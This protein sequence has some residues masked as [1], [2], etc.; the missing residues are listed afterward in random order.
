MTCDDQRPCS[1][2]LKRGIG[3]LCHDEVR[4]RRSSTEPAGVEPSGT[5]HQQDLTPQ[6]TDNLGPENSGLEYNTINDFMTIINDDALFFQYDLES[7]YAGIKTEPQ[8]S[9]SLP[10]IDPVPQHLTP[11]KNDNELA[12]TAEVPAM[13][14]HAT[15]QRKYSQDVPADS[16]AVDQFMLTAADPEHTS[17]EG[18]LK[19]VI[20]A[21]HKAGLLRPYNY[22]DGYDRLR[23]YMDSYMNSQSKQRILDSLSAVRPAFR[24]VAKSLND[25]D[26]VKVEENFERML[27]NYDWMFS[28]TAM[29]ACLWRRTGEIY[30]GNREFAE[31]VECSVDDLR[32]GRLTIYELMTEEST[33]SYWEKYANV[34]FSS[35]Q[36]AVLTSCNIRTR[37]GRKRRPCSFSFTI[38]RDWYN[39]PSCIVG[40]FIPI[41]QR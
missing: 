17:A 18:R 36:K 22:A 35:E 15:P 1:R 6:H 30:R 29:P 25:V 12:Q 21:K 33:V 24:A 8:H 38:R 13:D 16:P 28:A 41:P 9:V 23:I 32:D 26:L 4:S 37:D 14:L 20:S 39:I 40:N 2:C 31:L 27:L 10:S 5:P 3:H 19:Q 34:A 11:M 7:P